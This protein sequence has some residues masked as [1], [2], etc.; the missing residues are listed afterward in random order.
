MRNIRGYTLV[1]LLVATAVMITA[2][3][4]VFVAV[5]DGLGRNALWNEAADLHQ[6]GRVAIETV[7]AEVAA[8]GTGPAA[9]PLVRFF[10]PIEPKRRGY[11]A[12]ASA[13][14]VRY[15][16]D[17]A[18]W[19]TLAADLTP[20]A[21]TARIAI[22]RGCPS[23]TSVCGFLAGTDV[24]IFDRAGNWDLSSVESGAADTLTLTSIAGPR[25]VTYRVG[26]SIAQI[27]ETTLYFEPAERQLRREQPGGNTLPVL[28]NVLD[29]QFSYIGDTVPPVEPRP[30]DGE[31][32]CLFTSTGERVPL[33]VLP[34]DHGALATL[35]LPM[36]ADGPFCGSGTSA[37]DVDLL[38]IRGIHVTARLQTGV[39][40]LRGPDPRLFARP[41]SATRQDRMLPDIVVSIDLLP[42][43]LQR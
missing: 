26:A 24:V 22:P 4:G 12:T 17:N 25:S 3:V 18:A 34:T 30:M 5:S 29:L 28:D 20:D 1:E 13:I 10:A 37:Y 35:P 9:G 2:A 8:A 40:E 16:P 15:A 33:P 36:F 23:G 38:R 41:G 43:G 32:N 31:S 42:R 19:S 11:G 7:L 39:E 27:V 6:R 21:S 14:T